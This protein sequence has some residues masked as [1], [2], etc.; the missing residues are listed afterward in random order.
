[1]RIIVVPFHNL[2][3]ISSCFVA[4]ESQN[5]PSVSGA[6]GGSGIDIKKKLMGNLQESA[7][8]SIK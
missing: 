6:C 7:N 8:S 3:T 5:G 2:S 4:M 1:M